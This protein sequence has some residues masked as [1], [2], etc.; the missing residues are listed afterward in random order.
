VP[1]ASEIQT[2]RWLERARQFAR[3][4]LLVREGAAWRGVE[5]DYHLESSS[6]HAFAAS[7]RR[8]HLEKTPRIEPTGKSAAVMTRRA[9]SRH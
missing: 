3:E 6:A 7:R 8:T 2:G 9:R 5:P 1:G 4:S